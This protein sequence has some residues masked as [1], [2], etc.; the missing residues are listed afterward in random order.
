MTNQS[1]DGE[2]FSIAWQGVADAINHLPTGEREKYRKS[3]GIFM[4]DMK[5]TL[6][7]IN[8]ANEIIRRDIHACKEKHRSEDMITIVYNS[9][10]ALDAYFD[11]MVDQCFNNIE[12]GEA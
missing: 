6:G 8:N 1:Q 7:L 2:D 9:T 12:S 11:T 4:H 3:L 10:Q 5:H